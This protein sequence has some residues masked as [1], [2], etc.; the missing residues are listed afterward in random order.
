MLIMKTVTS[1]KGNFACDDCDKSFLTA[2]GLNKH[3][4]E[5][6]GK[7]APKKK[8]DPQPQG[9]GLFPY[10]DCGKAYSH[11]I[12]L[13]RHVKRDH[14]NLRYPCQLCDKVYT[15]KFYF[16]KHL[17]REHKNDDKGDIENSDK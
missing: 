16:K 5:F 14:N 2:T 8:R 6:C 1:D 12:S 4:V 17:S 13:D 15:T 11:Q 10:S 9:S 3:K 7:V